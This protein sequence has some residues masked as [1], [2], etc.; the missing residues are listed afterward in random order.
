MKYEV[1]HT[2]ELTPC[3]IENWVAIQQADHHLASPYFRPEFTQSVAAVRDDVFVGLMQKGSDV[4][5]FFPFHLK[6][7][8][9][10]RPVGLGL[11]DYHGVVVE[12]DAQWNVNDLLRGCKLVRLEFD[13]LLACQHQFGTFHTK[14]EESPIIDVSQGFEKYA[15]SGDKS[16]RKQLKETLRKREKLTAEVGE[17]HFALHNDNDNVLQQL[18]ELKSLQCRQTGTVDFFDLQWC[19]ALIKHIHVRRENDFG[20]MLSS[21]HVGDTLAAVHFGMY[22]NR[23]WHSW[24]PAYNHELQEYSPG[25]ILLLELIKAAAERGINHIDLGKGLSTY[26]K[27]VMTGGIAVAEG[28]ATIPSIRSQL[29]KLGD[30]VEQWDNNRSFLQPILRLPAKAIQRLKRKKRYI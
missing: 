13:H 18:I 1:I 24:F 28:C 21:L 7:G 2:S 30:L 6:R 20:G 11:S 12:P 27:R 17:L 3:L 8:G 19:K 9:I 26:K 15:E 16:G 4:V 14:V 5:G 22:S 10:A 29:Y 23:I 25:S